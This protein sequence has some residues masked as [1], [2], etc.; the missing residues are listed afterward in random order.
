MGKS[1][2]EPIGEMPKINCLACGKECDADSRYCKHCGAPSKPI[3]I[4]AH[5]RPKKSRKKLLVVL[6]II[7]IIIGTIS[8]FIIIS[9]QE[10]DETETYTYSPA[11]IPDSL[12]IELDMDS[13]GVEI[14][15][16]DKI[17][18]PVVKMVYHKKW[19]GFVASEPSFE[20]SSS[21]VSFE[22]AFVFGEA[23]S[24]LTVT[25][26]SD[27]EYDIKGT[28]SNGSMALKNENLEATL[29]TVN[30]ESSDGSISIS[31]RDLTITEQI[32]LKSEDGSASIFL[33]DTTIG[34]ISGTFSSGSTSINLENCSIEDI[35]IT[36]EDGSVSIT[37]KE[38][39]IK[40]HSSW[41]FDVDD[42]S[43]ALDI[44][45]TT[46]PKANVTVDA[47]VTGSKDID[48]DFNGNATNVRAK[49]NGNKDIT[50]KRNTGFEI[51]DSKTM[52]SSNFDNNTID[53]FEIK[54]TADKGDLEVDVLSF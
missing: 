50:I 52:E 18:E 42:G 17:T 25:L 41:S 26:R 30:L 44:T 40:S 13:A 24:E 2:E 3:E 53:M 16:T 6:L 28:I 49:L 54:M 11:I 19:Q 7:V 43:I 51:L 5:L 31:G 8:V 23:D 32:K 36:G 45:Q 33:K 22:G 20:T 29:G 15:F 21:K 14:K 9:F 12:K 35:H 1:K 34:D 37:T 10:V 47:S 38:S 39:K 48:V 46:A 27:V 4:P